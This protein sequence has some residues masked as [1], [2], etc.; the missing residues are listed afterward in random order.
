MECGQLSLGPAACV[1]PAPASTPRG[2]QRTLARHRQALT[3]LHSTPAI[4]G[5]APVYISR[6]EVSLAKG[7]LT[8]PWQ[9]W[10]RTKEFLAPRPVL[11]P[12]CCCSTPSC[13][14]RRGGVG[15]HHSLNLALAPLQPALLPPWNPPSPLSF[16]RCFPVSPGYSDCLMKCSALPG[17][18][19]CLQS[20]RPAVGTDGASSP[21]PRELQRGL[22]LHSTCWF[23]S[24]H[25]ISS[26]RPFSGDSLQWLY[27]QPVSAG[28]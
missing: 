11:R 2:Q 18:R 25:P 22:Y 21:W 20:A 26:A 9:S 23:N 24:P 28:T 19:P 7:Y 1:G 15:A 17:A 3:N 5:A 12:H 10:G 27:S 8:S 6:G 4:Q 13:I 16:P 14:G